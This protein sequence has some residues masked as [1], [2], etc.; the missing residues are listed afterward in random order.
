MRTWALDGLESGALLARRGEKRVTDRGPRR[1]LGGAVKGVSASLI[2]VLALVVGFSASGCGS[3]G[4]ASSQA[5]VQVSAAHAKTADIRDRPH[6]NPVAAVRQAYPHVLGA[7]HADGTELVHCPPMPLAGEVRALGI[8]CS[9]IPRDLYDAACM[10]LQ[11]TGPVIHGSGQRLQRQ[12]RTQVARISGG[13]TCSVSPGP[14]PRQT[15]CW[16]GSQVVRFG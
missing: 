4:G 14:K 3:S 5:E 9:A 1:S 6:T 8:N 15:D 10:V 12:I 13:W 2:T 11:R 16:R 7:Y